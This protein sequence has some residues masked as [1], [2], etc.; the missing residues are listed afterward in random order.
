VIL[1]MGGIALGC[2][3]LRRGGELEI[4]HLF[5][6]WNLPARNPLLLLGLFYMIASIVV[7]VVLV[8]LMFVFFGGIGLFSGQVSGEQASAAMVPAMIGFFVVAMVL[9]VPLGMMIWL[10]PPL[11]A[12]NGI[13]PI[14]AMKSSFAASLRNLDVVLVFGLVILCATF[15]AILPLGLGLLVLYPVL[16]AA[17]YAA[18]RRSTTTRRNGGRTRTPP[19]RHAAQGRGRPLRACAERNLVRIHSGRGSRRSGSKPDPSLDQFDLAQA[20][21]QVVVRGDRLSYRFGLSAL[22]QPAASRSGNRDWVQE[23]RRRV[24]RLARGLA[25]RVDHAVRGRRVHVVGQA[26]Q[27]VADVDHDRVGVGGE[28]HPLALARLTSRP[29]ALAPTSSV[30]RLMSSCA[31]ARTFGMSGAVI[32]G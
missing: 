28:R 14:E 23:E 12:L 22:M 24:A 32:G 30:I 18:Y 15:V 17:N 4:S 26:L 19:E 8:V 25:G 11:V 16:M 29:A 20:L 10:A 9:F 2:D 1:M 13:E 6:A 21:Q 27:H 31:P 3:S 5:A 7:T